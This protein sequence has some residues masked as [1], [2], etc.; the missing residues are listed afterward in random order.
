MK[1]VL[2]AISLLTITNVAFASV[3]NCGMPK[4]SKGEILMGGSSY[5]VDFNQDGTVFLIATNYDTGKL[6]L[7]KLEMTKE[8]QGVDGATWKVDNI[9]VESMNGLVR[10]FEGNEQSA[11]CAVGK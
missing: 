6:R 9:T 2:F 4:N 5:S 1:T 3:Y 7:S 8:F 11:T 10:L